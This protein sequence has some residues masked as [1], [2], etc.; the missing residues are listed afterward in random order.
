MKKFFKYFFL[1][2]CAAVVLGTFVWLWKKS[3]PT[4]ESYELLAVERGDIENMTV[5]TGKISPRDEVLIKP[6]QIS[7]IISELR[8]E[9]GD[10]VRVGDVIAVIQVIPEMASLNSAESR[11]KIAEIELERVE[12]EYTR[13]KQLFEKGLLSG[14]DME[15]ANA[16]WL[17][18]LEELATAQD[19]LD[20]VRDGISRKASAVS[21]TQIRSTID[22][23]ILDI[24]V[25]VGNQVIQANTFNEGTTIAT[26]A[27]MSD[28]IFI[29]DIDE[30]EVG[31]IKVGTPIK[32]TIGALNEMKFDAELEFISPMSKEENGAVLF[33]FKAA[34]HIPDSVTVRAGYSAN[35]EIILESARDALLVPEGAVSFE[36]D[37]T[38][39]YVVTDSLSV[40]Q[41]F[42]RTPVTLG[43][44]N[45]IKAVI[46]SGLS[47]SDKVR[48]NLIVKKK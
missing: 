42:E 46:T 23:M 24:P 22:G 5:T 20:I 37:S 33:E 38:F 18:A 43:I 8:K 21:N 31:K 28:M 35:A 17:K 11:V 40:P 2:I 19:N 10:Y 7:G 39:V 32:I 48:G 47:E 30:T 27:N 34:A 45:G 1:T 14:E 3:R 36:N 41:V 12:G 25:K 44:S 15:K 29:E 9:A 13:R 6:N 4:V 26:I 16:D